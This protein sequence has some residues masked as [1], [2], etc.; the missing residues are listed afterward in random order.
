[1]VTVR[2]K[3]DEVNKMIPFSRLVPLAFLLTPAVDRAQSLPVELLFDGEPLQTAEPPQF[4]CRDDNRNEWIGCEIALEPG[5]SRYV[6]ARP[7][8]G[9]Y[10]LHV[11]I[12]ENKDNPARFPG[13]YDVFHHFEVT[14]DSPAIVSVDMLKLI[15]L[16]EPWDNNVDL[17]G[18][19]ASEW[20]EKPQAG[21]TVTFQWD[22]VAPLAEY[23]HAVYELDGPSCD[24]GRDV[25]RG[26]THE[27]SVRLHLPLSS[28]GHYFAFELTAQRNGRSIGEVF[29]HDAG[30][31]GWWIEFIVRNSPRRP[32]AAAAVANDALLA[33]WKTTIPKPAW[34]DDVPPSPLAIHSLGDLM[35][36]WQSGINDDASR[37]RFYKLAYQAILDHAGDQH[38]V[39]QAI[40]LMAYAGDSEDR[41]PLLEFGVDHFF[42]YN[43]RTDNCAHCKIGELTGEMVRDLAEAYI[44]RGEPEAAIRIIERLV[45]EREQDVSAYNLALT[46]ETK[47]RAY[48]AM[49]DFESAKAAVREGLRRF[50]EGWQADQLRKTLEQYE[51]ETA[52]PVTN[53]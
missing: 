30:A 51:Q 22:P 38:L 31:Q 50:P 29:T 33:E 5:T 49:N 21:R 13:D 9:K 26:T 34:W 4:S 1:M 32:A 53:E 8:P 28:P 48:R 3:V 36:V 37:H 35:A 2:Q 27:A 23:S 39:A 15:H 18:M 24:R 45:S 46:F 7:A 25:V 19:L 52:K 17:D 43:Q 41:F 6:M 10:T 40:S 16:T 44:S 20:S 14:S 11:E 47:S 12:D 42:F